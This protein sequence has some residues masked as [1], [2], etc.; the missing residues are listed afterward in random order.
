MKKFIK[1]IFIFFGIFLLSAIVIVLIDY[2]YVGNQHLGNYQASILDKVAR[3]RSLESPK[4]VMAGNSSMAFGMNSAMLEEEMC[5]PVVN[6]AFH[7]GLGNAMNENM[8]KLGDLNEGDIVIIAHHTFSDPDDIED[9]GLALITLEKHL[10]LWKIVRP[11]DILGL[12]RAYPDYFKDCL[13]YKWTDYDDNEVKYDTCYSRGAFNEYGDI[14]LRIGDKF[15]F[16]DGCIKIPEINDKCINRIN[17]LNEY[18]KSKGATLVIA[19]YPIADGEFSPPDETYTEF[20]KELR[21]KVDCDVISNYL[22]YKIP[23]EYFFDASGHLS[24]E[25]ADIRTKQLIKDLKRWKGEASDE[26]Q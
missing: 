14:E 11:K 19:A 22:D 6:L 13:M 15:T 3:Y 26:D 21:S 1:N 17:K 7:A 4:I 9:P 16:F 25:G 18:V 24:A 10:D 20:E 12:V 2:F 23:Y 8:I 5:M